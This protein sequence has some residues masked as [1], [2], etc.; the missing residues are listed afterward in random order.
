[1]DTSDRNDTTVEIYGLWQEVYRLWDES[2]ISGVVSEKNCNLA[3]DVISKL[4]DLVDKE[5]EPHD[6][7]VALRMRAQNYCLLKKYDSALEDL[8]KERD[9]DRKLNDY[10]RII[11]CE[12]LISQINDRNAPH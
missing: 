11:K 12:E 2:Q 6:Y 7:C 5:M 1:M 9:L 10:I 3:I 8:Y 4:L